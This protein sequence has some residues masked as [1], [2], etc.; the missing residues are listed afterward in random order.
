MSNFNMGIGPVI[1]PASEPLG[2][3][4]SPDLGAADPQTASALLTVIMQALQQLQSALGD[5]GSDGGTPSMPS[6]PAATPEGMPV[7]AAA[8]PS[9]AAASPSGATGGTPAAATPGGTSGSTSA[10]SSSGGS[11]TDSTNSD[12]ENAM[13]QTQ[14]Q[15]PTLYAKTMKDAQ[16]GNGNGLVEDELQAYKEGAITKQQA[17]EEVSGAQSLANQNGG[18]RING[19]V[20]GEAQDALGKNV[21]G[22]GQTRI[23]HDIVKAFESFTP[24]GAII[25]G[26]KD[27][28][29][30]QGPEN[31]I[32]AGQAVTQQASQTAMQDMQSADPN[33]AAK[34][35]QDA[36]KGDGNAMVDDMVQLKSEEQSGQVPD[37]F[38][39]QDAQLLG[40]Q[41][42]NYGKG[43]VNAHEEQSFTQA[44][45]ADTLYRGSTR[46]SKAFNKVE[47]TVGDIMGKVVSPVTDTVGG[48]DK[49]VHGDIKGAFKEFGNALAGAATDAAMVVAPEAAPELEVGAMAAEGASAA[50]SA[51]RVL[52]PI[53]SGARTLGKANDHV[54]DANDAVN[55]LTGND[56]NNGGNRTA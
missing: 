38:T 29:S 32:Q 55:M 7:N 1:P 45:G 23:E 54:N 15:D 35:Q 25:K 9:G 46:G 48:V 8:S 14:A 49:L 6:M 17:T 36:Q 51:D 31:V 26:S 28:T 24:I 47:D 53:L 13:A 50:A 19:K 34:F 27:K 18:G 42:G 2:G 33:L 56:N 5:G 20:R 22:K 12:L 30:K 4:A 52:D 44:F 21:I 41:V 3:G 11:G 16:S 10:A 43:K 37:T 39:D 40:S